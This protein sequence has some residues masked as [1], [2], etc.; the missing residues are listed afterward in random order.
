MSEHVLLLLKLIMYAHQHA[1]TFNYVSNLAEMIDDVIGRHT[2]HLL[3]ILSHPSRPC[4]F[5]DKSTLIK[6]DE[7]RQT[8]S[9]LL[10]LFFQLITYT[11]AFLFSFI[12][13]SDSKMEFFY[14]CHT[15]ECWFSMRRKWN[16]SIEMRK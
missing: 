13:E 12:S 5:D 8:P 11:M 2:Q 14:Y 6:C 7:L 1:D 10:R 16:K 9:T 3:F 15:H 4:P